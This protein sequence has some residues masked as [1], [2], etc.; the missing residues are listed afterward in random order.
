MGFWR[1]N[2][3]GG[4]ERLMAQACF[5]ATYTMSSPKLKVS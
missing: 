3:V 1:E 2:G 5:S 4:S